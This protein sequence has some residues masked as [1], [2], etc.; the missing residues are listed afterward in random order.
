MGQRLLYA[1]QVLAYVFYK[2]LENGRDLRRTG[3]RSISDRLLLV[4][5]CRGSSKAHHLAIIAHIRS[6]T[7]KIER[8]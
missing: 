3:L 1:N 7:R 2:T 8:V 5:Q 4:Q 6:D